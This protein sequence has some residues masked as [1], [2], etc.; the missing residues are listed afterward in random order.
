[1]NSIQ[2]TDRLWWVGIEDF[3]LK[4]FDII[5]TT[6]YG[7]SYNSYVLK[8][9][10]K[11]ALF[12]TEKSRFFDE[13]LGRI[14]EVTPLGDVDYIIM[15]H[16]EPDHADGIGLLLEKNPEITVVGTAVAINNLKQIINRTDFKART[17]KDKDTLS[18]GDIT[19]E[20]HVLPNL[21]WPDTMWTYAKEIKT[22]FPCDSFGAHFATEE[23]LRSKVTDEE[24]Y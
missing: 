13:Y 16:T 5:M 8:G 23:V 24:G 9:S 11:T 17:V 22:L 4:V 21:H 18:L 14:E 3:D 12:E 20:F 10:E 15:N 7:T 2:L 6:E 19:L 1:M